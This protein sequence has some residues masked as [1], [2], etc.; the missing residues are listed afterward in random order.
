MQEWYLLTSDTRPNATGGYE[1]DA[2][3]DY[4]EDAFQEALQTDIATTVTLYNYDLS[5]PKRI[6]CIIQGNTADTQLKALERTVL[7]SIGT[8]KAGM[9]ILFEDR[10]WLITGYP[11]NNKIYE[12]ATMILCQYKLRWQDDS[13]K[14]IERWANFTSASKYDTGHS[15]NQTI[16]LTSNNFTIWIPEDD[17]SATLD[18]RR[19]FIDRDTIRPT[20]VFEITRSDDVLYLFGEEHGGILS[21]IA[22]K[23][24]LN[25][26]VDRPDLG[27]CDY[28][29]PRSLPPKPDETTDLSAVISGKSNLINGFSR[30]YSA[31]F[32]DSNGDIKQDV[33]F[34][35]NVESD[36]DVQ[37]KVN[38][39]EIELSV[40]D[41]SLIGSSFILQVCVQDKVLS[42]FEITITSLY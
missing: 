12:K 2:F 14:V 35:W 6:R 16:M 21:F 1:N 41:K 5:E 30:T 34:T 18:T 42:E 11:G 37:Q 4:K 28:K 20:K 13:G 7:A 25:L 9:Y 40:D 8:L 27:L 32:K 23:D 24:E 22:D 38:G 39:N 15:G 17:D 26:E 29:P 33:D 36:F 3:L 10:Y 19:V 31:E